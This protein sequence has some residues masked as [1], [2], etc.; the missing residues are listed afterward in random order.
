M[1]YNLYLFSKLAEENCPEMKEV[2]EIGLKWEVLKELYYEYEESPYPTRLS[3]SDHDAMYLWM[4]DRKDR[5]IADNLAETIKELK[6]RIS[7]IVEDA[8]DLYRTAKENLNIE[9]PSVA[10]EI[11]SRAYL[12][13]EIATDLNNNECLKWKVYGKNFNQ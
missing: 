7:C 4:Q 5:K 6:W 1:K 2:Y 11:I 10:D 3:L 8:N 9:S 13:I 12:N